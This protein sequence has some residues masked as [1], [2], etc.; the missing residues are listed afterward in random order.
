MANATSVPILAL[1][2]DDRC[3]A[4]VAGGPSSPEGSSVAFVN[5][6][7]RELL[8]NV[9][10]EVEAEDGLPR[11]MRYVSRL[12]QQQQQQQM[13]AATSA[14]AVSSETAA[15][16]VVAPATRHSFAEGAVVSSVEGALPSPLDLPLRY[17]PLVAQP[18]ALFSEGA[19]AI[20]GGGESSGVMVGG[21]GG[22]GGGAAGGGGRWSGFEC[23]LQDEITEVFRDRLWSGGEGI[24]AAAEA[25]AA[26]Y[27]GGRGGGGG[28]PA[29]RA[30]YPV[31]IAAPCPAATNLLM[32]CGGRHHGDGDSEKE[33]GSG[34]T[35]LDAICAYLRDRW[36]QTSNRNGSAEEGRH[37]DSFA[38]AALA[39]ATTAAPAATR[40]GEGF[41][42]VVEL[43]TSLI[44][45]LSSSY[46]AKGKGKEKTEAAGP[47]VE[48]M[49]LALL[50][51]N[52][53]LDAAAT[54]R[55][56]SRACSQ[57][58]AADPLTT[59][60]SLSS[61]A[62]EGKGAVAPYF[63]FVAFFHQFT[64]TRKMSYYVAAGVEMQ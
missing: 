11:Y 50:R 31:L 8:R 32:R 35:L 60:S 23:G 22:G 26:A 44:M 19:A 55:S 2:T 39:A 29:P 57:T 5:N 27:G 63:G 6:G 40:R 38:E 59:S 58:A 12:Q 24:S 46:A 17:F 41:H 53:E 51:K 48:A 37:Y 9:L 61:A 14:A 52:Y 7:R 28:R 16:S 49:R 56:R 33:E 64:D 47:P 34:A 30:I 18:E 62:E 15:P 45:L 42:T 43:S 20:G 54:A 25:E 4:A 1:S 3:V 10:A 21:A 13:A 36:D